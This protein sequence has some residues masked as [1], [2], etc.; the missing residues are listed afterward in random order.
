MTEVNR[1]VKTAMDCETFQY[2][3]SIVGFLYISGGFC[4]MYISS[5]INWIYS[6]IDPEDTSIEPFYLNN[7]EEENSSILRKYSI[8]WYFLLSAYV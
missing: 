8:K 6:F 2:V 7:P 5:I 4:G 1:R 3:N